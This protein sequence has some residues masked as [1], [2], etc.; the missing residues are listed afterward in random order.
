M[1]AS[2]DATGNWAPPPPA[3]QPREQARCP[4]DRSHRRDLSKRPDN[5][6]ESVL[7]AVARGRLRVPLRAHARP[8]TP[9]EKEAVR[10]RRTRTRCCAGLHA[11]PTMC[12][13]SRSRTGPLLCEGR[14]GAHGATDAG[15]RVARMRGA[16]PQGGQRRG[17][18]SPGP[19]TRLGRR[20]ALATAAAPQHLL[21]RRHTSSAREDSPPAHGAT[22]HG[23]AEL[24]AHTPGDA[25]RWAPAPAAR[26]VLQLIARRRRRGLVSR[27]R[28]VA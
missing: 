24:N 21:R 20:F 6:S 14:E 26:A 13:R 11:W 5:P 4:H 25:A 7:R 17:E 12:A 16:R 8:A 22:T 2:R 3:P 10:P 28:P 18:T 15:E 9:S 27:R 23:E 19:K 1:C